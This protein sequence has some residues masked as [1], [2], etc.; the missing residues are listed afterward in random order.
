V[1]QVRVEVFC[2]LV[3]VNLDPGASPLA[4]QLAGSEERLAPYRLP[5]RRRFGKGSGGGTHPANWKI[6]VENHAEGYH[7]PIAHPSLVR[8]LDYQR[9]TVEAR[10][11]WVWFDAP[12]RDK[13]SDNR[14]ERAYQRLVQPILKEDVDLVQNVQHGMA[15]RDWQPPP[16]SQ[17][18]AAVAWF[19]DRI[20]ADLEWPMT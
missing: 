11:N 19:A 13:P 12:M 10:D 6:V 5:E 9:Y 17:R 3:F 2:G 4:E 7:I 1:H 15:T 16:L 8:L 14:L 20:G 18:E